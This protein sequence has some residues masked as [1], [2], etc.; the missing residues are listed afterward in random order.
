MDK[1]RGGWDLTF[2][3]CIGLKFGDLR[4]VLAQRG[5]LYPTGF[6]ILTS[7]WSAMALVETLLKQNSYFI[8]LSIG[9]LVYRSPYKPIAKDPTFRLIGPWRESRCILI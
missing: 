1:V 4:L 8:A 9:I 6:D 2:K 7:E 3:G 5:E